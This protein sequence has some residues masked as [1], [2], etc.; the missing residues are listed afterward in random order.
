V[1][2]V[3]RRAEA[4]R[5]SSEITEKVIREEVYRETGEAE[6]IDDPTRIGG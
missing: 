5:G 3:S 6:E 1:V 4:W 2:S